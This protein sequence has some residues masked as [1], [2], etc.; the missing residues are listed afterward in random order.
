MNDGTL[1]LQ[2]A[3]RVTELERD[4]KHTPDGRSLSEVIRGAAARQGLTLTEAASEAG[5]KLSRLSRC[6]H[7]KAVLS[8]CDL[9]ELA[10]VLRLTDAEVAACVKN[11]RR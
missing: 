9:R 4:R 10:E 2:L 5:I 11:E 7:G 3:A 8:V 6:L 1:L